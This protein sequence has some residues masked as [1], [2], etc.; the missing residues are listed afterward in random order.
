[1]KKNLKFMLKNKL[2]KK[3]I[4]LLPRSFDVVGSILIFSDF[5]KELEKK[6][7]AIGEEI[8]NQF[9]NVKTVAKKTKKYSRAFLKSVEQGLRES[10]F[11][12]V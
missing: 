9:R 11:F 6:E 8:L 12:G 3:E 7:K 1:M 5:P 2:S 10:S 4:K